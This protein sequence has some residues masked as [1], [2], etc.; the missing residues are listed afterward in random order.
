M[1]AWFF[2]YKSHPFWKWLQSAA[3]KKPSWTKK[4]VLQALQINIYMVHVH[5]QTHLIDPYS[6]DLEYSPT[7][8]P[9]KICL[10]Y[11]WCSRGDDHRCMWFSLPDSSHLLL[12]FHPKFLWDMIQTQQPVVP[13]SAWKWSFNDT[14]HHFWKI[15]MGML[16]MVLFLVSRHRDIWC[17]SWVN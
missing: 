9:A 12:F 13:K 8:L 14:K 16:P 7:P 17:K 5:L 11:S 3:C 4:E 1:I 10:G 15:K 6:I 2:D